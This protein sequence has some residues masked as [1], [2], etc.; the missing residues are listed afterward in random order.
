MRRLMG[1]ESPGD[2]RFRG[3]L[4]TLLAA[5][6]VLVLAALLACPA[7]A[8]P[9]PPAPDRSFREFVASL[10]PI[11]A[12]RGVS[13]RTFDRAFAGVAFDPKVVANANR[14]AEF[15]RPIWEYIASAASPARIARGRAKSKA[16]DAWL[17][18]AT[19][20]YGVDAA[21]IMG[22]WGL[23]TDFGA[24]AGSDN[25][26][27]ALASLAYVRFRGDYFRD[28]LLLALVILELGDI[29]PKAMRGSWAGAMGQ[30]QF[31]P[32]SFLIYAVDFEGHGRR[33][34]WTSEAD[35][36]GSTANFLASNGWKADLPWGFE[37]LLPAGYALTDADSS[38]GASFADFAGRGVRRADGAPL[39][40][41]GDGR[42]LIPAGLNGPVFL[43]TSNFEV[44]KT[45][46]ASTSYALAVALL[47]DAIEGGGGMVADWP[48]N[49]RPL[50]P[51]QVRKLQ[52]KLK[53]M[54][55]DPGEIDGMVGDA[56]RSAVR[57]YQQRHGLTP[58]G[59]ADLAL[60][61]RIDRE[62]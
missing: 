7:A 5:A 62:R 14:Q 20:V 24:F 10:W 44:I 37:V 54:G 19:Q 56:M 8:G 2:D 51:D 61:K 29:E 15:I 6:F 59:Y 32:S 43:I 35:A 18:K 38:K 9:R 36:I 34:I 31:M 46:N 42:L 25:V 55:Y 1:A 48:K 26:F 47:G 11:A 49:D 28:E 27:R 4:R 12:E 45:Y 3:G 16:D 17:T 52:A 60:L 22:I 41:K 57:A 21:V 39:P 33:D 30:T 50:G 40:D 23:E 13:H 58:D 53:Q